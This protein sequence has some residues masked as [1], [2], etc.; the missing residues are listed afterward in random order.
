MNQKQN[1]YLINNKQKILKT[2]EYE[3]CN[4]IITNE[5]E[6]DMDT[7]YEQNY[8]KEIYSDER[9]GIEWSIE[10]IS[11]D[12]EYNFTVN[13][14]NSSK[15]ITI[16]LNPLEYDFNHEKDVVEYRILSDGKL[17][18]ICKLFYII[19]D[20]MNSGE[21]IYNDKQYD[22][23]FFKNNKVL[24]YSKDCWLFERNVQ[25]GLDDSN[26]LFINKKITIIYNEHLERVQIYESKLSKRKNIFDN[27]FY[28]HKIKGII[29]EYEERYTPEI[30]ITIND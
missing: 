13:F 25:F 2:F 20:Y 3:T 17:I 24:Y 19:F 16:N 18:I 14:D 29:Y 21:I 12:G 28:V 7:N 4:I 9:N 15:I 5:I 11:D 27:I 1:I 23:E 10:K 22:L 8:E 30:Y 6:N 26:I